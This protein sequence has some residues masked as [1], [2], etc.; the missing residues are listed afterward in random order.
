MKM[1]W[2]SFAAL[3][4]AA[5]LLTGC[6]GERRAAEVVTDTPEE[7]EMTGTPVEEEEDA[8]AAESGLSLTIDG[9]KVDVVWEDN[10]SVEAL[11]ALAGDVPLE[12]AMS[13][14]GGFEQVGSLG[15]SLVRDDVQTETVPGDIVL[16]AGDRIVIFYGSNRWAYT[17]LGRIE[18]VSGE[19]LAAMLGEHD[20]T[21]VLENDK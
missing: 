12:V 6:A 1:L 3:V 11:K 16:Y 15:T 8:V 13:R 4:A 7:T 14:Y 9:R 2:E 20:V 17:R 5:C 18:G 21:A 19:D 10:A